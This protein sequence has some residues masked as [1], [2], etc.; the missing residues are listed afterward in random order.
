MQK[1]VPVILC[2]GSGTRFWLMSRAGFPKQFLIL[3]SSTSLFPQAVEYIDSLV[4]DDINVSDTLV[5][6]NEEHRFLALDQLRGMKTVVSTL[7]LEPVGCNTAPAS[8]LA[9]LEA[10]ANTEDPIL[11]VT[12]ADQTVVDGGVFTAALQRSVRAA[13]TR[14]IVILGI[15]P[16]SSETGYGYIR[17]TGKPGPND[18][19]TVTQFAEKP[20]LETA[21]SI[22]E[23]ARFK[24]KASRS[25]PKPPRACKNTTTEL[26]TG[27]W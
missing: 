13:A 25:N 17:H 1:I 7:L 15:P 14:A 19:H 6:A 8:T 20:N 21:L 24:V 23:E 2:G 18:E 16:E 11:V 9:A 22:K 12:P 3:S 5:I 10:T 4:S 27:S 26:S